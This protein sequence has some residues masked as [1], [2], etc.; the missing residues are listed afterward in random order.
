MEKKKQV[1]AVYASPASSMSVCSGVVLSPLLHYEPL[2]AEDYLFA[3]SIHIATCTEQV[4]IIS[5]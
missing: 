5:Y 4:L 2:K 1:S 3:S